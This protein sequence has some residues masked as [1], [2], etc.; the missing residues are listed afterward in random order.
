M[1]RRHKSCYSASDEASGSA[2]YLMRL[3][4][5]VIK[6]P[7]VVSLVYTI[8]AKGTVVYNDC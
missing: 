7:T 4:S 2:V 3:D 6:T 5:G 8:I 1:N